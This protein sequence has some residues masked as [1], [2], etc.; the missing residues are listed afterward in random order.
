M[1]EQL[2]IFTRGG[3][4]LWTCKELSNALKGSPI[5][6]LIKSCLLE[7]RSADSSFNYD[8]PSIGGGG[9]AYTLK[10]TFH[11]D[12]GLVFVAVYQRILHLLYVDDLLSAVRREFAQIYDPKRTSYNEFDEIFRQLQQEAEA[13]AEEM[14]KLKQSGKNPPVL[15]KKAGLDL[16]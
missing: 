15:G 5:E 2:L 3:L 1:L 6:T 11:N 4:I 14:R 10:W 7:E 8:A 13:R 9:G 12:L 16:K